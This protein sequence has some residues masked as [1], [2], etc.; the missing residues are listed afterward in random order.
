MMEEG[1]ERCTGGIRMKKLIRFKGMVSL[2][3]LLL[4]VSCSMKSEEDSVKEA[5]V[6]AEKG[7]ISEDTLNPNQSLK[8]TSLYLPERFHVE[9]E[10]V[11]NIILK[12]G[13]QTYIVFYNNLE[14]ATSKLGASSSQNEEALLFDSFKDKDKFGYIRLMP[15]I[16]KKYEMIVGV[17]GVKITTYTMKQNMAQ[18]AKEMMQIS[19]S[20]VDQNNND[21]E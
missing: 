18:D 15:A 8:H 1:K 14:P 10:D 5:F 21:T 19:R 12:D 16:D 7:F 2:L 6:E 11:S 13:E 4:V 20:F 3:L 9:S 17:G